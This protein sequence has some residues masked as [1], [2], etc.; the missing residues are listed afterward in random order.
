M[1]FSCQ[2]TPSVGDGVQFSTWRLQISD[3][4]FLPVPSFEVVTGLF[5]Q[6]GRH[7]FAPFQLH[8]AALDAKDQA[9]SEKAGT[10]GSSPSALRRSQDPRS[11]FVQEGQNVF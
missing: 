9:L 5:F 1:L 3:E 2:F 8:Q 6:Y 10:F 7:M 11:L 4:D